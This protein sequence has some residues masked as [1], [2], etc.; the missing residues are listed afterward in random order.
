MKDLS[1][2][3]IPPNIVEQAIAEA[4]IQQVEAQPIT[5]PATQE[6]FQVVQDSLP[7]IENLLLPGSNSQI[8]IVNQPDVNNYKFRYKID[9]QDLP[10][11]K[12]QKNGSNGTSWPEIQITDPPACPAELWVQLVEQKDDDQNKPRPS[13]NFVVLKKQKNNKKKYFHSPQEVTVASDGAEDGIIKLNISNLAAI[14]GKICFDKNLPLSLFRAKA[15]DFWD[16]LN[17]K[18]IIN[19][20]PP[21][22]RPHLSWI[23]PPQDA[24]EEKEMKK[25]IDTTRVRICFQVF[26]HIGQSYP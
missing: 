21:D 16:Y 25:E 1:V 23:P 9:K 6:S 14:G 19:K 17:Q 4:L 7:I 11:I 2:T 15:I 20:S 22:K 10:L 18:N 13:P 12:G 5:A 24:D 8:L 3:N 26:L